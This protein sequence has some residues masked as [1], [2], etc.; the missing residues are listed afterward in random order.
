[1]VPTALVIEASAETDLDCADA[2]VSNGTVVASSSPKNNAGS[3][4][5]RLIRN[6][7]I[8][9]NLASGNARELRLYEV[10]LVLTAYLQ[11]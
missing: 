10:L 7:V 11:E 5:T 6:D 9:F 2:G 1:M 3:R 4:E 8:S